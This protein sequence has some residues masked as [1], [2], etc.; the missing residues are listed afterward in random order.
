MDMAIIALKTFVPMK[1]LSQGNIAGLILK[2]TLPMLAGNVF[3]Q[4]YN[5]V[6]SIVIGNYLGKDALAAVGASFPVMFALLSLIFGVASGVAIIISQYFGAKNFPKVKQA[7]FTMYVIVI[8]SSVILTVIGIS[9]SEAIFRLIELPAHVIPMATLYLNII[10]GGVIAMFAFSATNSILRGLGD[11]RT[12]L[13]FLIASSVLNIFLDLL[14]VLVF[15][16]GIAGVAIAS[17]CAEILALTG[18]MVYLFR[19]HDLLKGG[20]DDFK[21]DF[22]IFVKSIKIGLPS[23]MQHMFVAVGMVAVYRIVNQ[24]DIDVIAAYSVAGR[25][26]SFA[27]MPAM[28]F[29]M[30]LT[31]FVGQNIGA[32][33]LERVKTG[34][35][36]TIFMTACISVFF[37]GISIF[38]GRQLMGIFTNEAQ[39]V[40][41]GYQYLIVVASFYIVFSTMFCFTSLYR[42][43]GD[44]IIP[45]LITLLA[46]WLVR[47]PLS[48]YLSQTMGANG[49]WWGIP[50]A[51]VVGLVLSFLYYFTGRW[52]K[53][54]LLA[55]R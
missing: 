4:T 6:D 8:F 35:V 3:Q 43:A 9:S 40:E 28:N 10:W 18:A 33:R 51:W 2:F 47:I 42:G 36:A 46:L 49:I 31:V 15:K 14:F 23:G 30:A 27:V 12:P 50:L 25:I 1:D 54:A 55:V 19:T 39:V 17:I 44:T 5:V 13:Y 22:Q 20:Y 11:S 37:T 52:K 38:F 32:G 34:L 53:N 16:W 7:I 29:A 24:F 21:F 45:M 41:I 26:D 48:W